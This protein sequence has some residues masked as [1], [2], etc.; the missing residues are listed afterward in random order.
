MSPVLCGSSVWKSMSEGQTGHLSTLT[1]HA[2]ANTFISTWTL[3]STSAFAKIKRKHPQ[4]MSKDGIWPQSRRRMNVWNRLA[5]KLQ[6]AEFLKRGDR[7]LYIHVPLLYL[8]DQGF[9]LG[10]TFQSTRYY[11][12][13]IWSRWKDTS[14]K[15]IFLIVVRSHL[16]A[17]SVLI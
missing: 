16:L 13:C 3:N 8:Y 9:I 6:Q 15:W 4:N 1:F 12:H 17:S 2:F 10:Y 14:R 11:K 5:L 7:S